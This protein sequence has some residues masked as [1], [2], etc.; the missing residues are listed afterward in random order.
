MVTP[1]W[2]TL[3]ICQP[4]SCSHTQFG[5][6]IQ[7]QSASRTF[8]AYNKK[9]CGDSTA[10]DSRSKVLRIR[11]DIAAATDLEQLFCSVPV[12]YRLK[13]KYIGIT[14]TCVV[15]S[16]SSSNTM[17]RLKQQLLL[18]M[19]PSGSLGSVSYTHLTL[20]TTAEV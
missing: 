4:F 6:T 17:F 3:L 7:S 13:W 18:Q 11:N 1:W 8:T 10:A 15:S 5:S 14:N 9:I 16:S 19:L 20:P 2:R 12:C